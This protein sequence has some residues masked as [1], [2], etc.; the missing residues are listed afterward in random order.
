[1]LSILIIDDQDSIIKG[2][3]QVLENKGYAVKSAHSGKE[4]VP[5]IENN[6]FNIIKKEK[7]W[8]IRYQIIQKI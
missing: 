4:A 3:S 1:M 5:I 6:I 8:Q 2:L 7:K